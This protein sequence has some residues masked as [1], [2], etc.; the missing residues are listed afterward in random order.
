ML[1]KLDPATLDET[2]RVSLGRHYL[3]YG[4]AFSPDRSRIAIVGAAEG[5][6]LHVDLRRL[7]LTGEA[8]VP[9]IEPVWSGSGLLFGAHR[10]TARDGTTTAKV[11][12][13]TP[14][15]DR[16]EEL[17]LGSERPL[18]L[19]RGA[20]G[21]VLLTTPSSRRLMVGGPLRVATVGAA[22]GLRVTRLDKIRLGIEDWHVR[23][24]SV[25]PPRARGAVDRARDDLARRTG[26]P[27]AEINPTRVIPQAMGSFGDESYEIALSARGDHY[28][29]LVL[30]WPNEWVASPT[31]L[32]G[33]PEPSQNDLLRAPP[34][35]REAV[36]VRFAVSPTGRRAFVV[37]SI[38]ALA[39][40]ELKSKRVR[41]RVLEQA[42]G[43]L[44]H[45][46]ALGEDRVAI[47][48]ES[49]VVIAGARSGERRRVRRGRDCQL[50]RGASF[51]V[52]YGWGCPGLTIHRLNGRAMRRLLAGSRL[53]DVALA[54]GYAYVRVF[55]DEET[56]RVV[57][58]RTGR[59]LRTAPARSLLISS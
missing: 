55:R 22:G 5:I 37:T 31:R 4:Y 46:I 2:G 49:E 59:T 29:Y 10:E 20:G 27:T 14:R 6:L 42:L 12:R 51:F 52:V 19:R 43:R 41:Y 44:N 26:V 8:K 38:G 1:V 7:R 57:D 16:I 15:G 24:G 45:V 17:T 25:L 58:L 3:P 35:T 21:A 13:M 11:Y 30:V 23:A 48:G 34:G 28:I 50:A 32:P 36:D 39:S 47:A 9:G 56:T 54:G 53:Y 18:D 33:P 40:V